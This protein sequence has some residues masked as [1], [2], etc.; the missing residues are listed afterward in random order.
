M[1]RTNTYFLCVR[2]SSLIALLLAPLAFAQRAGRMVV[3]GPAELKVALETARPGDIVTLKNG[4]WFDAKITIQKGGELGKPV[5]IRAETPGGV[6]LG[7]SSAL[8][9]NAPYVTVDGLFFHKGALK[10]GAVIQ[11]NSHHGIVRNTAI[12]DYNPPDFRAGYHWV[13]FCGTSNLVDRCYFKGKNNMHAV[14][15]NG[16]RDCRYNSLIGSCFK[17]IPLRAKV[18]GREIVKVLGA[19]HVNASS[20]DGAFFTI[21]GNLFEHADGEGTEIISLKSNH[22]KVLQ[23][24][25][26]ASAGCLNIRRG[27]HNEIKNNII[28]GQGV[29]R[30]QGIRM[31]GEDNL[32]QGNFVSGC[33]YGIAVSSGEYWAKALTPDYQVNDRGGKAENKAHYPQNKRVAI[34]NNTTADISGADLDIGVKEYKKHWPENQ[35]VLIPEECRIEKNVFVRSNGGVSVIGMT[36]DKQPPL[37]RFS[38]KPN[39]YAG[40]V[41]YG[42]KNS[43]AVSSAGFQEKAIPPGWSVGQIISTF[44][45]LTPANVGPDWVRTKGF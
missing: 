23:N 25:I 30:A 20:P 43:F 2:L 9:I 38:F 6:I 19:G 22:N 13:Y 29:Q 18:N 42:G 32:I 26:L 10:K 39:I 37:E 21:E 8:E 40:N 16:E 7:G 4:N 36:P 17:D 3:V 5:E 15:Q 14:V 1:N 35:N 27:N 28:L 12:I 31:A 41:L 34:I 45:P 33:E 24:T 11:F 44:K